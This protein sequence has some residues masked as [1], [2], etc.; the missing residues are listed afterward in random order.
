MLK[1]LPAGKNSAK[2]DCRIDRRYFGVPQPFA[3]GQAGEVIEKSPMRGQLFP[4]KAQAVYNALARFCERNI[5]ALFADAERGQSESSGCDT[6]HY[7][8]IIRSDVASISH[9]PGLRIGLFPEI[10][11]ICLLQF[12][13]KIVVG[14]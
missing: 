7:I 8:V 9:H 6:P 1:V 10:Q 3:S 2:Q 14:L 12:F 4:Q 5:P 13:E 11:E